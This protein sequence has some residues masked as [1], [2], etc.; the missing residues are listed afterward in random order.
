MLTRHDSALLVNAFNDIQNEITG[1][2]TSRDKSTLASVRTKAIQLPDQVLQELPRLSGLVRRA[3]FLYPQ[4]AFRGSW[5]KLKTSGDRNPAEVEKYINNL[6]GNLR[7]SFRR[8]TAL[9]RQKGDGF[10]L[11]GID[12]GRRPDEPVNPDAI[13][14]VRWVMSFTNRE[15][16]IEPSGYR[17]FVPYDPEYY[18][19]Y[20]YGERGILDGEI[21][22]LDNVDIGGNGITPSR[23]TI[24]DFVWHKSRVIRLSGDYLYDEAL[25]DNSGYHDSVIQSMFNAWIQF[26]QGV[27]ASSAMLQDYDQFTFGVE[28]FAN[29][30]R[31]KDKTDEQKV[32][33]MEKIIQRARA[34]DLTRSVSR[35]IFHDLKEEKPGSIT[36]SYSG[37]DKIM[38]RLEDVWAASSSIPKFKLFNQ[39]GASG[40]TTGVQAATILKIEWGLQVQAWLEDTADQGV[41]KL[42]RYC[43]LAQDSPLNGTDP[44]EIQIEYPLNVVLSPQEKAELQKLVSERDK[45]NIASGIYTGLEAR[46]QYEDAD[47]DLN[48][49]LENMD[50]Q[51]ERSKDVLLK[52]LEQEA[53]PKLQVFRGGRGGREE[54][55][56]SRDEIR[57][58]DGTRA[59]RIIDLLGFKI[60]I[61]YFPFDKRH[62]KVLPMAYGYIMNTR[63][64]DGMAVD[65]YVLPGSNSNKIFE[66]EQVINGEFDEHKYL[67][68]ASSKDHARDLYLSVMPR[69]FLGKVKPVTIEYLQ[70]F[71]I[72]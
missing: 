47:F 9:G 61:Q 4:D 48:L 63:G 64:A 52:K 42:K 55:D 58:D 41:E 5:F 50:A 2:G 43:T 36:R 29:L 14:S 62:G 45:N 33:A 53:K 39:I 69:E 19:L 40:L 13:A 72:K 27:A 34:I 17:G 18:R 3:V 32:D 56:R 67:I 51:R 20:N 21:G 38:D 1:V 7:F 6:K 25:S 70:Q 30:L 26:S 68:G 37:A 60:G 57:T 15:I 44:A 16:R 35:S 71:S 66:I 23:G 11:L 54:S 28:G 8:G 49:Y 31:E 46:T 59:K 12:D 22:I 24:R 10:L 65:V